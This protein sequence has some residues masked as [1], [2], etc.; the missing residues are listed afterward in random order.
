MN[1]EDRTKQDDEFAMLGRAGSLL[2]PHEEVLTDQ[3]RERL[4]TIALRLGHIVLERWER[5]YR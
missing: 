5:G 2:K 4:D 1:P 3:Q